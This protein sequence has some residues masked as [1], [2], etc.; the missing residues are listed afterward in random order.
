MLV[1]VG[2]HAQQGGAVTPPLCSYESA[3]FNTLPCSCCRSLCLLPLLGPGT[4]QR[5]CWR[6]GTATLCGWCAWSLRRRLRLLWRWRRLT[7][8]MPCAAT[9]GRALPWDAIQ[10]QPAGWTW[11]KRSSDGGGGG[12]VGL[13]CGSWGERCWQRQRLCVCS[14]QR[15]GQ[16]GAAPGTEARYCSRWQ[17]RMGK[18]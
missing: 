8:L 4:S 18:P 5:T 2:E 6:G 14:W 9:C 3:T 15:A 7:L 11:R 13:A 1:A 16:R 12:S 10:Q 17:R